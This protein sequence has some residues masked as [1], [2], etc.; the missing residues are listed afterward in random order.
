L[1]DAR[2]LEPTPRELGRVGLDNPEVDRRQWGTPEVADRA[3]LVAVLVT[4][5]LPVRVEAER[6]AVVGLRAGADPP[7]RP[8]GVAREPARRVPGESDLAELAVLAALDVG[9]QLPLDDARFLEGVELHRHRL[10]RLVEAPADH[11]RLTS[12][13]RWIATCI[14]TKAPSLCPTRSAG[15]PTMVSRKAIVSSVISW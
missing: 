1:A 8:A 5:R 15:C 12:S 9:G 7:L 2:G 6:G 10:A 13:G 14:A 11:H 3:R 4:E